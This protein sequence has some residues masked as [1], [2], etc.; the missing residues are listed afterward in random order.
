[1]YLQATY[2]IV[3]VRRVV[4][5]PTPSGLWCET[6]LKVSPPK[7]KK[8][9]LIFSMTHL[10]PFRFCPRTKT[11]R[12]S[13]WK[14][15]IV[16]LGDI[17]KYLPVLKQGCCCVRDETMEI[18]PWMKTHEAGWGGKEWGRAG[19]GLWHEEAK[20]ALFS[21]RGLWL[22]SLKAQACSL[23]APHHSGHGSENSSWDDSYSVLWGLAWA[24]AG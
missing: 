10:F 4:I 23:P 9:L 6:E 16:G 11:L 20:W 14:N 15:S 5:N 21:C 19:K 13:M 24:R 1:M 8:Q 22:P 7:R 12:F 18:S 3:Y 17:L 2:F